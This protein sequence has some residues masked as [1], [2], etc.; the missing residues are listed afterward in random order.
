MNPHP[1]QRGC[2][3]AV[4]R[5][6]IDIYVGPKAPAGKESNW[7]ASVPG[8]GFFAILRL[9]GPTETALNRTWRAGDFEEIK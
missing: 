5:G 3:N 7:L 1:R 2:R 8:R 4:S 9:Y 6:S